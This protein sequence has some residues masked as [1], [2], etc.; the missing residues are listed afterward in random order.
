MGN[1]TNSSYRLRAHLEIP[2]LR[3]LSRCEL[4]L[5]VLKD[6]EGRGRDGDD[7]ADFPGEGRREDEG[8]VCALRSSSAYSLTPFLQEETG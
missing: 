6:P 4:A 7:D 1:R 2:Q 3:M 8:E 5:E